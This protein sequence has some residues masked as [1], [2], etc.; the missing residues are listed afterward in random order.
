[1]ESL[2]GANISSVSLAVREHRLAGREE[3]A[4]ASDELGIVYCIDGGVSIEDRDGTREI[5]AN[6]ASRYRAGALRGTASGA[7]LLRWSLGA[8]APAGA[9]LVAPA[10]RLPAPL[11]LRCDRVD[12]PLGGVAY[13]HTHRGPGIRV[14]LCGGLAVTTGGRTL[15]IEPGGA[16]FESGPEPVFA[17]AS[18]ATQTSF[19]RVMLLPAELHAKSS[20]RYVN[21]ED[22]EKPKTQRY[23]MF[24]DDIV[25]LE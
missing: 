15:A 6:Q 22:Q 14:L 8:E 3:L 24:V 13:T 23:Q 16:W 11:L 12:F 17:Q 2:T 7:K 1:M 20:I 4:A 21:P 10:G 5:G 18:R 9:L 25:D 19:V